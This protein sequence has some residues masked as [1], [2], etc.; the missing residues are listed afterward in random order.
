[1][2][3][4]INYPNLFVIT[5]T[6]HTLI[7]KSLVLNCMSHLITVCKNSLFLPYLQKSN[8]LITNVLS[9]GNLQKV[10]E[11]KP[12]NVSHYSYYPN[13][14][15]DISTKC[16]FIYTIVNIVFTHFLFTAEELGSNWNYHNVV[17]FCKRVKFQLACLSRSLCWIWRDSQ[18]IQSCP[19]LNS[20]RNIT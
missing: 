8:I 12:I 13:N 11:S 18:G 5:T 3:T 14:I 19:I 10:N 15:T 17:C 16:V 2:T 1:M 6:T 7:G 9:K 20:E 4:N